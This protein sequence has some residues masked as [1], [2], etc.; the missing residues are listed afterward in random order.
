MMSIKLT[1]MSPGG[2]LA[3]LALGSLLVLVAGSETRAQEASAQPGEPSS[4]SSPATSMSNNHLDEGSVSDAH[5]G[6]PKL[7]AKVDSRQRS[8]RMH[9]QT[10]SAHHQSTPLESYAAAYAAA[11]SLA[12]TDADQSA[13][14]T[15]QASSD[16][17]AYSS[18]GE[19]PPTSASAGATRSQYVSGSPIRQLPSANDYPSSLN[20]FASYMSPSSNEASYSGQPSHMQHHY[21]GKSPSGA[22]SSLSPGY[23]SNAYERAYPMSGYYDRLSHHHLPAASSPFMSSVPSLSGG[24]MSSASHAISHWT[25]GFSIG[26]IICGLVALAIGAVIL[27]APFFLIYLALMGNFS[28]SGTLSLTNPT[29][30]AAAAGGASTTANGRRKRLAIFEA[31]NLTNDQARRHPNFPQ[32]AESVVEQLSPFIDLQQVAKTFKQLVNSIEKYSPRHEPGA[33]GTKSQ[34]GSS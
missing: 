19:T 24:L 17:S 18:F 7:S 20:Y 16:A 1:K 25:N 3:L 9:Q 32:L 8:G 4:V 28:G 5:R 12:S 30:S 2:R 6:E 34:R 14:I 10:S 31:M 33:K 23:P 11:N 13:H 21:Y 15:Q 27:G 26:E 29:S 22:A